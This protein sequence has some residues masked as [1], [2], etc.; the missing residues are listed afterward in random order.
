MQ[1]III[2]DFNSYLDNQLENAQTAK[3]ILP[4][5]LKWDLDIG[6]VLFTPSFIKQSKWEIYRKNYFL[7]Y[8]NNHF[9]QFCFQS[10][11]KV[12]YKEALAE[13]QNL[14]YFTLCF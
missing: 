14:I 7:Q 9:R 3:S 1:K 2:H 13:G 4:I 10:E 8:Y 11:P 12:L 6:K 5:S